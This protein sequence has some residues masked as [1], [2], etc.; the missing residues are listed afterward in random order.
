MKLWW[1]PI[2]LHCGH[3][4]CRS[5]IRRSLALQPACPLC[6]AACHINATEVRPNLFITRVLSER[7]G[8]EIVARSRE[9]VEDEAELS[10]AR[11]GLFLLPGTE[12]FLFPGAPLNLV[13]W[14]PR[15]LALMQRCLENRSEFG[16]QPD[17]DAMRGVSMRIVAADMARHGRMLV[18]AVAHSR[19][20]C[21]T[22]PAVEGGGGSFGLV[23]APL[24]EHLSDA[25]LEGDAAADDEAA[26]TELT[27]ALPPAA[28][29]ALRGL[30]RTV[31]AQKIAASGAET[32][33]RVLAS[34]GGRAQAVFDRHGPLPPPSGP[35]GGAERWSFYLADALALSPDEKL[36]CFSTTSTVERLLVAYS[37]L[38]S[39]DAA[40]SGAVAAGVYQ[41][42]AVPADAAPPQLPEAGRRAAATDAVTL[43][44]PPLAHVTAEQVLFVFSR[45]QAVRGAQIRFDNLGQYA[46]AIMTGP[47]VSSLLVFAFVIGMLWARAANWV[48]F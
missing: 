27:A 5:C 11:L 43:P 26:V 8:A 4:F 41:G 7:F 45:R 42:A 44:L 39:A 32:L 30:R 46:W 23:V 31:Q 48:H 9:A 22:R 33:A 18:R 28:A 13:V 15:Y 10:R 37:F 17:A 35:N 21:L 36:R 25:P 6:R 20:R 24:V 34:L 12:S 19:Y 3:T 29:Q 38:C 40:A 2:A 16:V 14:E 47:L 1:E